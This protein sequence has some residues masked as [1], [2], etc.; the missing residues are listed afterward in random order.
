MKKFTVMVSALVAGIATGQWAGAQ[1]KPNIILI[2]TDQQRGDA[3]GCAGNTVIKTPNIDRLASDGYLFGNAY[4]ACPS[5]TPA[6]AGLLTGLSP[7]HH[8]MLGYGEVA[9][10]YRFEMPQMLRNDGYYTVGIGKMHWHPQRST[11]GF[12]AMLIDESGRIEDPYFMSDYRR[13]FATQAPGVNPDATGI[14]WNDHGARV[15]QLSERLHPTVWTADQAIT[16]IENYNN[17]LPLMMKVS[18][19]RPHSPYDPPQRV[20]DSYNGVAMPPA[21]HGEWSNSIG[22]NLTDPSKNKEAAFGQFSPEYVDNSR[23]H[24]YAAITFIDEQVGRL[25]EALKRK[26]MYDNTL[27]IF[28]SDHGDMMGDH[29][30]W[31]KTY[32][33]EGSAAIPMILKVPSA[34]KVAK[35]RGSVIDAPVELRDILPTMLDVAGDTVPEG[36]DGASMLTLLRSDNAPWRRYIDFEHATCYSDRNYWVALTD[37][38]LKYIWFVPTGEE[39]LFDL[40]RDAQETNNLVDNKKYKKQLADLREAMVQHLSERGDQWVKDGKLVTHTNKVLYSPN[41]PKK[42]QKK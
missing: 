31:R 17:D 5:S 20:L 40:D 9:E 27:I 32:A 15:Y 30:M 4:T 28:T 29:N 8:G 18:F 22:A 23:R 14:G 6:R 10:H 21:A 1:N 3:V 16:T 33:Y 2:M 13:W 42:T 12:H 39:Q 7:W 37:G 38:H 35:P 34:M 19:A 41:Y 26:G 11:H 36:M 25:I 24:Y